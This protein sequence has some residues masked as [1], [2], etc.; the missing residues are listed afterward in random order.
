[1]MT[2]RS[3]TRRSLALMLSAL[4][5]IVGLAVVPVT[6]ATADDH[7]LV[8]LVGNLQ[9]ELG[10]ADD[11]QP[12]C[13]ATV[14][15]ATGT[16]DVYASVFTI[17]EGSWEYKV[18]IGGTW[19]EAYGLNGGDDNIPLTLAGPSEIRVVF[20]DSTQRVGL[21]LLDVRGDYTAA[22][23]ELVAPPVRQP[24]SDEVFYFVLTDRFQNGDARNDTGGIDGG[25]LDHGFDPADK[26]FFHG[27]DIAG[28]RA[29]L[30]YIEG[31]GTTAIWLTPS[32]KNM[33]VQGEGDDASAGYHG[34]WV[35]DFTQIDPHLGTNAELEA[36][37]ADAH[38]RGIKVYFD[39]ITNHT[40]DVI[41]YEEGQYS[42][43][44]KAAS[45]YRDAAGDAFD[46]DDY[47]GTGD[48]PALDAATS[49]PYTPV[50]RPGLEDVK[51]PAWL[52]D[53]T[54]YHNRGNSTWS[55]ESV[56]YGDFEGLDDLMTE[57]PTVVDGFIDV[58]QDWIDLG[59]DGFRIDTVKHVN[60]E[61][62]EKW[63][64]EV[65]AY[66]H[67]QGKP[68]FFMFGEVYDA[69]PR[70]LSPYV[71]ETDMNSVLDFTFQAE[72]TGYAGGTNWATAL[73]YLFGGDDYY[74]TPHSSAS[75]LPTFLGNHDM[76]RIGYLLRGSDDPLA[77]SAFAHEIM[78]LT[79]G[80]P[81]V[82]YGDEQG[83][84]GADPGNDKS[85]RQS[86]FA[87][88]VEEYVGQSLLTGEQLGS[89]DR[90][91]TG[92]ELYMH[93]ADLAELRGA[94]AALSQGAQF[95]L[96]VEQGVGVYA[97]SRVDRDEKIE[98]L[99]ALN[100]A[101]EA[102]SVALTAL[103]PGATFDRIHGGGAAQLTSDGAAEVTVE[104]PA[105]SAVVYRAD[106]AVAASDL[107][108]ALAAPAAGAG[109]SGLTAVSADLGATAWNETSFAWRVAGSDTWRALGTAESTA[110]RVF[111]D[112]AGLAQGTLIEYRAIAVDAAGTPTATS[113]YASVGN[114][115]TTTPSEEPGG[116]DADMV[117]IPGNH[118]GAMGCNNWQPECALAQLTLRE[119]GVYEG[120]FDLPA[121][122]YEYKIAVGGS[123][124][125]NYGANGVP[126][127]D[128][129]H[130]THTGGPV[131]FYFDPVSKQ[132]QNTAEGPIVTLPGSFQSQVG[133]GGDW[134]PEC[135]SAWLTDGDKDGVYEWST[136]ALA[137]GS[138]ETKVAH[139]LSWA[140]NYGVDGVFD[141]ANYAFSASAGKQVVFRYTLA[142]HILEIEVTDP[143]LAGTGQL[144]AHWVS[145]D[146]IAWPAALLGGADAADLS[147]SL[148]HSATATLA[149]GEDGVTGGDAVE[150]EYESAGLSDAEKARFPHLAGHIA[151]R[152]VGLDRAD[153][154][155]ILTSQVQILQ[156]TSDA[157]PTAFTGV[158]LPGVLD[159]L[160]ADALDGVALGAV[161]GG[162]STDFSVWAP[163]AQDV[164]LL[165]WDAD[166]AG[167]P[168]R[169]EASF[170]EATGTW[171]A[172]ASARTAP[173]TCGR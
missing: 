25:R 143:P 13:E 170:D 39:I 153:V 56:T 21:E 43:I 106:R 105:R 76:G 65:L 164:A 70:L 1:M 91:D 93:I 41:D 15:A 31:L 52:N 78:F 40:A 108:L 134:Q 9:S 139:G 112:V 51:V 159:D 102:K 61:F 149:L 6:A 72:V 98:Y 48:F 71:R 22:D 154:Q 53:P 84:A 156:E 89:Q 59:I 114:A 122:Q 157:A 28:L 121:G 60:F 62:W 47:A 54:L 55:G 109:V 16:A 38:S 172:A 160:Y 163:T 137:A 138:Y 110:P 11:W 171:S 75:A 79:R 146:T 3:R 68:D 45:P 135:L 100:N 63:S 130:Y 14:L 132:F 29:E 82:Y 99:V 83:F 17:P 145:E 81:V 44:D 124:D 87:S 33:P 26:G 73:E 12:D 74:T 4:L 50:A 23:E 162:Y 97:F 94:H 24:G 42:Y 19:D 120:T 168:T 136:S 107:D 66:A 141:G 128:N 113:T 123:W 36:L 144:R 165:T 150:L 80:Q 140:E 49:F 104:V 85:A 151:L 64:E 20:D 158:Q 35:T 148:H 46:P 131:T 90:F 169:H 67:A 167:E 117:T 88:Q 166:G 101:A 152:P 125:E 127:G 32:F 57:H 126:G 92:A 118:G 161:P 27:G 147:W 37:I 77:R 8:T 155:Q 116:P 34:Y 7:R 103:T 129:V 69:D 133:C 142:T 5:A 18:A 96:H 58:Y 86:L 173:R 2:L 95:E 119:D 10:C 30:D 111:H 115:V